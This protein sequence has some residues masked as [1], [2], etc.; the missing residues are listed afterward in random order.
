[1]D[2]FDLLG[3]KIVVKLAIISSVVVGEDQVF[4]F[5]KN[6]L[7]QSWVFK[8]ISIVSKHLKAL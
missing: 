8:S 7:I 5:G 3:F 4:N 2:A 6:R 1:M